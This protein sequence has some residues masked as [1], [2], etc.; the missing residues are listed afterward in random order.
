[1]STGFAE[2]VT[3]ESPPPP[4]PCNEEALYE[5][6]NGERV[7]LPPMSIYSS[8]LAGRLLTQLD[9]FLAETSLGTPTLQALLILD[10]EANLRRRPNVAFVSAERWPLDRE[11]PETGDWEVVPDLAVEV[12]SPHDVFT[13]VHGKIREYFDHGVREVWLVV[14]DERQVYVYAALTKVEILDEARTL[15]STL[16]PGFELSLTS[17]FRRTSRAAT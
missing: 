5:I 11:I 9:R 2:P 17:L 3:A 13:N 8:L 7:E 10:S 16:L 4:P 6:V 14:P 12:A 1:M 15:T